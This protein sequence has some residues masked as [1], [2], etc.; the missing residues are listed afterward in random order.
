MAQWKTQVGIMLF[1]CFANFNIQA[2]NIPEGF[3]Y[4]DKLEP[5]ISFD[6][7]YF[8]KDNFVGDTIDGY[9]TARCIIS[10]N[11]ALALQKIQQELNAKNLGLKIYD[12]YR[13]QTAVNH[14][15]RWAKDLND[16]VRKAIHYP[17]INKSELFKKG[18]ISSRS[19]HSRGSSVDLTL[20]YTAGENKGKELDMGTVWDYFSPDSWPSSEAVSP[21]QKENRMLLQAIMRKYGFRALKEEWWHF[22]FKDEAFPNTY[23]DFNVE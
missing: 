12:A 10:T 8:S 13:P 23:F 21:K 15:V 4:L 18:Y 22:T 6:M 17:E 9:H 1:L 16:T 3:T 20:I 7:R 5:S 19:G 2:Q 11:A 14:F